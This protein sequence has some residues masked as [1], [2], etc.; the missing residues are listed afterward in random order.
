[1]TVTERPA[2][3]LAHERRLS[4]KRRRPSG[5]PPPLPRSLYATGKY[6]VA[7]LIVG[8][9]SWLGLVV[10]GGAGA[11]MARFDLALMEPILALRTDWLTDVML[12]IDSLG[13]EW[14]GLVL[15]WS[16]ILTALFFKRFRHLFVFLASILVVGFVASLGSWFIARPRPLGIEILG[17]WQGAAHPS[18]PIAALAVT[19]L[20]ILYTLVVPGRARTIGKWVTAGLLLLVSTAHIYLGVDH[21]TDVAAAII[22]GV[23]VPLA[24]FRLM[25]PN[26]IFPVSYK[27]RKAAHLDVE[28][29]RGEAIC[30][31]IEEQLGITLVDIE[32]FG[33]GGSAGSTPLRL[34]V[35]GEPPIELFGKLY[36]QTHLRS[37]RWYKLGRTLL[38][39]RLE[40]EGSFSTVRRLVQYEDYMLRV[41]RD[42]GLP[43]P[44]PYGFVEITPEREYLLVTGFVHGAKELLE[45]EI[46]DEVIDKSLY[47]IRQLWDAG[48]AHRDVKPSNILVTSKGVHL[49]DV[50]FGE[51]RPSPWRQA[52]DLA[53]MM[54]VLALR[55]DPE[56][57]YLGAIRYFTPGEIAEAFA[58]T[59][60]MTMPSQSRSL[61][62]NQKM[63]LVEQFRKM[64]PERAPISIQR[65]SLR[66]VGLTFGV[67]LSGLLVISLALS[68]FRGAGLQPPQD[69][70]T[71]A[72]SAVGKQPS[73]VTNDSLILQAQSVPTATL[74]PCIQT[75]PLGWSFSGLDVVDGRSRL[76]LD[77][78][79]A[80]FRA[81]NI[82]LAPSCDTAGASENPTDE[83][84]T[85]LYERVFLREDRY[86][87]TRYYTFEGGCAIYEFELEG[88][89]R[90]GLAQ[91]ASLAMSFL[92]RDTLEQEVFEK[93]GLEL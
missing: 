65:W 37:D 34:R 39:G 32:P 4:K 70:T 54:L 82:T 14:F 1:M 91:E 52:V 5:E 44:K 76:F 8:A 12:A 11:R 80:G 53:N 45:A 9:V 79:R 81:V 49:I 21:P 41:M 72:Y 84:G 22:L 17:H 38:Y 2:E 40:D 68:N 15:R 67:L 62:K 56:R 77:S 89:G 23:T 57:V 51:V 19:L 93:T 7:L 86:S 30:H 6:W 83:P 55:C 61:M 24:F 50:A 20:G 66:R 78:D 90:A 13:S 10:V 87:A 88:P 71:A 73:C 64:A 31:A 18:R 63:D 3:K 28:G 59:H 33:L 58:A 42:A 69:A 85:R 74:L 35:A 29:A 36:A 92:P 47:L 60:G 16:V 27:K 26:D 25:T 75:L 48:L 46:T 43:T